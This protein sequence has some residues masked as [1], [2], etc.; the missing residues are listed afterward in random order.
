[1]HLY[2]EL[3]NTGIYIFTL[4]LCILL[5][6]K[7]KHINTHIFFFSKMT[8]SFLPWSTLL[9]LSTKFDV[10]LLII[11]L[12]L[13]HISS[14]NVFFILDI[15]VLKT[16]SVFWIFIHLYLYNTHTS[17]YFIAVKIGF[18]YKLKVFCYIKCAI[19]YNL[20]IDVNRF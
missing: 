13:I 7:V 14:P 20:Q 3:W 4:I 1:M 18:R 19:F 12:K 15:G 8:S 6:R 11:W 17:V 16:K 5:H 10:L 2:D 9:F